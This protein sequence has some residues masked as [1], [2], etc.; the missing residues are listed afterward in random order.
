MAIK[1]LN[2]YRDSKGEEHL[3]AEMKTAKLTKAYQ[4]NFAKLKTV[5]R[6]IKVK[7]YANPVQERRVKE[8]DLVVKSL[9]AELVIRNPFDLDGILNHGI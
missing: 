3:I 7:G 5:K 1:T 2:K 8:L 9:K 6:A 4:S